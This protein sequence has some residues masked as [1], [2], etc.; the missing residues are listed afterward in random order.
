LLEVAGNAVLNLFLELDTLGVSL[1]AAVLGL[2]KEAV[3][4]HL[5]PKLFASVG[6]Q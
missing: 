3:Y 6:R 1:R 2:S 5:K 4:G